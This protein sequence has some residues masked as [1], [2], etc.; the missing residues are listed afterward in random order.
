MD[1]RFDIFRREIDGNFVWVAETETFVR[2]RERVVQDPAVIDYE[3]LIVN[4]LT[5]EK[6]HIVPA[7]RPPA[8]AKEL[9]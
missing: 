5:G 6:T 8:P 2:A 7:E 9:F 1:E 3:F 4:S